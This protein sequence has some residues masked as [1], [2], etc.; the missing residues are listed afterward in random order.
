[1]VS[2]PSTRMRLFFALVPPRDIRE[3]IAQLALDVARAA[4]GR[5]V[6]EDNVHATV[7]FLGQVEPDRVDALCALAE[8]IDSRPFDIVLARIGSFR[9]AKVAWI[10][11][12]ATPAQLAALHA[13]L[14]AL[15]AEAGFPVEERP[16]HP[17]LTLA[18]HC[19]HM[20]P[21][22]DVD[23]VEWTVDAFALMQ[24]LS[25]EGGVRYVPLH[26]WDLRAS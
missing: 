9:K 11:P 24:S 25:V 21:G 17:H 2:R 23:P 10:G 22:N 1:M 8:R 6:P 12:H 3:R 7:A 18:R 16:Y 5:P 14:T 15:L 19:A 20:V 13:C 26:T 4:R